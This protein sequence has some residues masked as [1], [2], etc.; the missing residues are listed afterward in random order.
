MNEM[1]IMWICK[2]SGNYNG[3]FIYIYVYV[4]EMD[5]VCISEMDI[6]CVWVWL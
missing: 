5:I 6:L 3:Y 2:W 1:D 4:S